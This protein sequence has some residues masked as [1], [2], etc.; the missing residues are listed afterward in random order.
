MIA[1][2]ESRSR[3]RVQIVDAQNQRYQVN[4]LSETVTEGLPVDVNDTDYEFVVNADLPGFSVLRR[5][6]QEVK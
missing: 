2:F 4:V 6:N 1:T 5:S 3:L